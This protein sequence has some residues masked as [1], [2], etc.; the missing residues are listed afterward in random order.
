MTKSIDA[1][2]NVVIEDANEKRMRML[3]EKLDDRRR[4]Q[5]EEKA[6]EEAQ[7]MIQRLKEEKRARKERAR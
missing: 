4:E 2:G 3:Q 1:A 5:Q 7:L 6:N